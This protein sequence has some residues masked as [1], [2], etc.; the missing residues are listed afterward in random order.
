MLR[1]GGRRVSRRHGGSKYPDSRTDDC[2]HGHDEDGDGMSELVHCDQLLAQ[3]PQKRKRRQVGG[4]T[5]RAEHFLLRI[6][7]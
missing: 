5:E 6:L 1:N 2:E 3:R 4:T 7:H